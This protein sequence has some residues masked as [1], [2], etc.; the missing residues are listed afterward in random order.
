MYF[1]KMAGRRSGILCHLGSLRCFSP[2]SQGKMAE[3]IRHAIA[4]VVV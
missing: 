2:V 1:P 3:Y 4:K